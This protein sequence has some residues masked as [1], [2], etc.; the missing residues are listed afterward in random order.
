MEVRNEKIFRFSFSW[1]VVDIMF[2]SLL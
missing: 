2:Q 1:Y